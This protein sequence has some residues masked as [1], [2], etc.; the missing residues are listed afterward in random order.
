MITFND[1][2]FIHST[3]MSDDKRK[4][5]LSNFEKLDRVF[6]RRK[7]EKVSKELL[8][9]YLIRVNS[10]GVTGGKIVETEAYLGEGD[11][12]SHTKDGNITDNTKVMYGPAGHAYVYLIYGM[13][14]CFNVVT[15]REGKPE[16]VFIRAIEPKFGIDLMKKRRDV[17]IRNENEPIELTNGP[18]K[19]CIAMDIDDKIKGVDLLG[20]KLFL[21][22]PKESEA[23]DIIKA[24]RI[25]ID[26]AGEAKEW[27]LRYLIDKNPYISKKVE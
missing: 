3:Y 2:N 26:Y 23:F 24:K 4:K 8:G 5:L 21:A 14:Y 15:Q 1:N 19:L 16:S 7:T 10:E 18:G 17:K 13:Y 11:P 27:K 22:E 9:K 6:Y 12:A 20:K 25:N